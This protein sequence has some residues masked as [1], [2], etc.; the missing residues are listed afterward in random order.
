M[1]KIYAVL[2]MCASLMMFAEGAGGVMYGNWT[3]SALFSNTDAD[4][5]FT[6]GFGYGVDEKGFKTG[7]FGLY[8]SEEDRYNSFA[9]SGAYGGLIS[10]YQ[11][12][13]DPVY[14]GLDLWA[15]IGYTQDSYDYTTNTSRFGGVSFMG[16]ISAEAGVQVF[17]WMAIALVGGVQAILPFSEI[18]HLDEGSSSLYST[19][20]A[21]KVSWGSF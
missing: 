11:Y 16:L 3:G 17:P 8:L 1:K 13:L 19:F 6:A 18:R 4:I 5:E 14:I 21:L 9:F 10:G 2:F 12:S 7:G 20:L 15:G